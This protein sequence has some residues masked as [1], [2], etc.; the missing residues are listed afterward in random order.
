MA[1]IFKY[2][3]SFIL[4]STCSLAFSDKRMSDISERALQIAKMNFEHAL[5]VNNKAIESCDRNKKAVPAALINK[6]GL[7]FNQIGPAL[8][9]LS[10]RAERACYKGSDD[11]FL[12]AAAIYR[13]VAKHYEVD[14][15]DADYY[16]EEFMFLRHWSKLE[17]EARYL[18]IDKKIREK[19][20][21]I[22]ELRVPFLFVD[23]LDLVKA[24]LKNK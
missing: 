14:S 13:Q 20:E 8:L 11:K 17:V 21:S 6:L 5:D 23:T 12:A 16:S 10:D 2:T 7:T 9:V 19:L 15:T 22:E 18:S 24:S 1:V 4:L 3:L